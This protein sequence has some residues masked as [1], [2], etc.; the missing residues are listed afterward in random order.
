[1]RSTNGQVFP[2]PVAFWRAG[3]PPTSMGCASLWPAPRSRSLQSS[4]VSG[5]MPSPPPIPARSRSSR[6][7]LAPAPRE[8]RAPSCNMATTC[9]RTA[10]GSSPRPPTS[11]TSQQATRRLPPISLRTP[12][13]WASLRRRSPTMRQEFRHSGRAR[14][15]GHGAPSPAPAPSATYRV[16]SSAMRN[17][18]PA[19]TSMTPGTTAGTFASLISWCRGR[20]FAS[21][22]KACRPSIYHL[23]PSRGSSRSGNCRT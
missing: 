12:R 20:T 8:S 14:R 11:N 5:S 7:W 15:A 2:A 17:A 23:I 9:S 19:V 1:M 16:F 22:G 18:W 10:H 4:S 6:A 13:R 21:S 3:W